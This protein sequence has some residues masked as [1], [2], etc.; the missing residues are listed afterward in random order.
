LSS[1][2][3]SSSQAERAEAEDAATNLRESK[4]L[5]DPDKDAGEEVIA[6]STVVRPN[7][8]LPEPNPP[9]V[10]RTV[11]HLSPWQTV[12][13]RDAIVPTV[14][15][16]LGQDDGVLDLR[17]RVL[18]EKQRA[19]P[20]TLQD[21][22]MIVGLRI[23][24][25]ATQVESPPLWDLARGDSPVIA[26]ISKNAAEIGWRTRIPTGQFELS[27]A[28]GHIIAR[29][30]ADARQ[31]IRISSTEPIS[32]WPW[33]SAEY[34]AGEEG[35]FRWQGIGTASLPPSW[36]T[37]EQRMNAPGR[38]LDL[39]LPAEREETVVI[40]IALVDDSTG[41]A[42]SSTIEHQQRTHR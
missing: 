9:F 32:C 36:T 10:L 31:V 27:G 24:F 39:R 2:G 23:E 17:A 38:R 22:R 25:T 19:M 34:A 16:R 3:S 29:I 40:A 21:E 28:D 26:T 13:V 4:N 41:W 42:F 33:L 15:T 35:G 7:P 12:L 8:A 1:A 20:R 11:F 30:S 5:S 37:Q 14:P 18:T 6:P